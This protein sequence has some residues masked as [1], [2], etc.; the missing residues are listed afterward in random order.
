MLRSLQQFLQ[1]SKRLLLFMDSKGSKNL[2]EASAVLSS[3]PVFL[4][5]WRRRG[6]RRAGEIQWDT[7]AMLADRDSV[8]QRPAR[9]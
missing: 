7:V 2:A 8:G 3:C 9:Y 4:G 5:P 1:A 6:L